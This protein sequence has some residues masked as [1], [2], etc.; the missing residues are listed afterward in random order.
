MIRYCLMFAHTVLTIH[1]RII[2]LLKNTP[3]M[4]LS[5]LCILDLQVGL[6]EAETS[7]LD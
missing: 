3:K 2:V 4:H 7:M 1:N 6:A 5:V